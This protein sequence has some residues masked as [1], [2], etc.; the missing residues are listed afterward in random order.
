MSD[1]ILILILM[2]SQ[3]IVKFLKRLTQSY[4]SHGGKTTIQMISP[5]DCYIMLLHNHT[6]TMDAH[7]NIE[8]SHDKINRNLRKTSVSVLPGVTTLRSYQSIPFH[9]TKQASA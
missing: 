7:H 4:I 1:A 5:D 9:E 8:Y 3:C 6:L 2:E